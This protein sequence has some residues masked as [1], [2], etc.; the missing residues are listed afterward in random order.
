MLSTSSYL[1][2]MMTLLPR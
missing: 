1:V 2:K